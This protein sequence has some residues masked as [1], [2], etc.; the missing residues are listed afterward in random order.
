MF[1]IENHAHLHMMFA[2]INHK[3]YYASV[4]SEVLSVLSLPV[5]NHPTEQTTC[6]GLYMTTLNKPNSHTIMQEIELMKQS[7]NYTLNC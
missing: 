4:R 1:L 7:R 2:T 3:L 5:Y 6:M